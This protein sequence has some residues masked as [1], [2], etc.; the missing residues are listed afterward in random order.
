MLLATIH[1]AWVVSRVVQMLMSA[2]V[3]E[4][5]RMA[6]EAVNQHDMCVV[7]GLQ[8]TGDANLAQVAAPHPPSTLD[9]TTNRLAVVPQ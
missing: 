2:K 8:S 6:L 4:L 9:R 7:I 1:D 5:A 3:D